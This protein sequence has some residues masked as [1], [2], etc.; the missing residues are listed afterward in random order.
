MRFEILE[1]EGATTQLCRVTDVV[2]C[3]KLPSAGPVLVFLLYILHKSK[4]IVFDRT[5]K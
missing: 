1:Q 5:P 2:L 3:L 4:S